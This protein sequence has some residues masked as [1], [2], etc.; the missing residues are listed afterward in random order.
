ME[1]AEFN[2]YLFEY[3]Y[4]GKRWDIDIKATSPEDAIAR[5]HALA[6]ASYLGLLQGTVPAKFG[7]FVR[8]ACWLR[9]N[10]V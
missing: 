3:S 9:N 4:K 6:N 2:T 5:L 7:M 1:K 10:F 8:L